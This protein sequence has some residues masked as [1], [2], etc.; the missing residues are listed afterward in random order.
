[1]SEDIFRVVITAAVGLACIAFVVQ[2]IV[3]L[4]LYKAVRKIQEK[5]D[6][7]GDK[8]EPFMAKVEPVVE[9]V[10]PVMD[11]IVPVVERVGPM[12]DAAT[13]A[14]ERMKPAIDRAAVVIGQIGEVVEQSKPVIEQ[15]TKVAANANQIVLDARPFVHEFSEEAVA[16]VR[17]ARAQVERIGEVLDDATKRAHARLE[18]IDES[19]ENTVGQVGQVGGA[20]KRAVLKPVREANGFAA[21]I[22][23]AVATLVHPRK[24]PDSAAQDDEMFI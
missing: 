17:S 14:V 11:K 16:G 18:Q 10:G 15:A 21:G 13:S 6:H 24:A 12:M 3:A 5:V 1:M 2:A 7:I 9:R 8:V 22:S 23:A 20:V 19:V 4:G